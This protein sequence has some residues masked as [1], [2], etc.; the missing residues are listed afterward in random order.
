ME[1]VNIGGIESF[2]AARRGAVLSVARRYVEYSIARLDGSY[3]CTVTVYT[4]TLL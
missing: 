3:V 4:V 1:A 2:A